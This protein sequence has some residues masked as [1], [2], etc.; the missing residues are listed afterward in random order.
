MTL[1][2]EMTKR[3][4]QLGGV[5]AN[6]DYLKHLFALGFFQRSA[7]ITNQDADIDSSTKLRF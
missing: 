3:E 4:Q 1:L 7:T 2:H 5:D 6:L